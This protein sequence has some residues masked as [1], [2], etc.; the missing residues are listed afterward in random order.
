MTRELLLGPCHGVV[1]REQVDHALTSLSLHFPLRNQ[2]DGADK[3]IL[4]PGSKLQGF[5]A[6]ILKLVPPMFTSRGGGL[7]AGPAEQGRGAG[8]PGV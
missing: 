3:V 8:G 6:M 2:E 7:G 4:A 1:T 5:D